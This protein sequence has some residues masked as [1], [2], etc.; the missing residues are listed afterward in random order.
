MKYLKL[1]LIALMFLSITHHDAY[2]KVRKT[3]RKSEVPTPVL[4]TFEQ[5]APNSNITKACCM[6][7]GTMKND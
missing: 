7:C 5:Q 1:V 3:I 2:G 6:I 4:V